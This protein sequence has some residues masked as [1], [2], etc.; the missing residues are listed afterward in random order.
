MSRRGGNLY[1]VCFA[2]RLTTGGP[3]LGVFGNATFDEERLCLETGDALVMFT[4]G[5][6][7][8]RNRGD[9]EFGED[10]LLAVHPG[11]DCRPA[12]LLARIFAGVHEFCGGADQSD[13]ITATVTRFG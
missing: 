1:P 9:E 2:R 7:E 4:D 5:V 10:R 12:D 3:I 6:T 13:D 8:A 11:P